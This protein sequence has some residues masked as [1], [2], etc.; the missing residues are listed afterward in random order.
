MG[1]GQP[2][3]GV[4]K[5]YGVRLTHKIR[6]IL[7]S[8]PMGSVMQITNSGA[9]PPLYS[10]PEYP[11]RDGKAAPP[12]PAPAEFKLYKPSHISQALKYH[13]AAPGAWGAGIPGLSLSLYKQ[14]CQAI[15]ECVIIRSRWCKA[16]DA[17]F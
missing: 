7:R 5:C 13:A 17:W 1:M 10:E 12:A 3:R 9:W 15:A 2:T 6:Y 14:M 8:H 16:H 4:K 11:Y